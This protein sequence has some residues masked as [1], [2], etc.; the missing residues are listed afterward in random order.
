[1]TFEVIPSLFLFNGECVYFPHNDPRKLTT[2]PVDPLTQARQ[3]IAAGA[4]TIDIVDIDAVLSGYP[5]NLG[6]VQALLSLYPG[7]CQL[8]IK[9]VATL[10]D[11]QDLADLQVD[12]LAGAIL[13]QQLYTGELS[14]EQARW[15]VSQERLRSSFLPPVSDN[16]A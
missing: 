6:Q 5:S 4:N 1:M 10:Q 12:G 15:A 16:F 9:A 7:Q 11:L 3:F 14:L 13:G 2:H 8:Y